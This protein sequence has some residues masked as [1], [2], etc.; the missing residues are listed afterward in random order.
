MQEKEFENTKIK[1]IEG[2]QVFDSRGNPTIQVKV[3]LEDGTYGKAIVPSGAST[4]R[5]EAFELR[6]GDFQEY[7]GKSVKRAVEN[8][9]KK[10]QKS[11]I[12][13]NALNQEKIDEKMIK[14]DGTK[15]KSK[16]GANAILGVSIAVAR[17]A[18]KYKEVPLYKYI[19]G[20]SGNVI[21]IPMMNILSGG[22]LS[23]NNINIQEFMI[24]PVEVENFEECMQICVEVYQVLKEIL[25]KQNLITAVGDEGGFAPDLEDKRIDDKKKSRRVLKNGVDELAIDLILEA[26]EKAGYKPGKDVAIALD[27]AANEMRKAAKS[28]EKEGYYFWK[29]DEY[30]TKEDM[31]QYIE[32]LVTK[33]PIVSVEDALG[34]ED[35]KEWKL[36]TRT[37]GDKIQ[38]VGD[39][40]FVTNYERLEKGIKN[41]VANAILIKPN[42]IGTLTETLR[43]I[44]LARKNGYKIIISHRSGETEDTF[45]ADLAVAT[46]AGQIKAGAPCRSERVSKYNRLLNIERELK[47]GIEQ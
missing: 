18:A 9:N 16:L 12:G 13:E 15:D 34:E 28:I 8:V 24:V 42:Q 17:A 27:M 10:I 35:W 20:M 36:L 11:L 44:N 40:L 38:I 23:D 14:L 6:D 32:N 43:T 30:K 25:K 19:G 1:N 33:Y 5:Y 3:T 39:D 47:N 26:I 29:T 45:I 4:G 37:I 31:I 21:P 46:N 41:K 2:M 22:R 7:N